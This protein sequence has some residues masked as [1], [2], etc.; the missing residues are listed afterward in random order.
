MA[1]DYAI[2]PILVDAGLTLPE[3]VLLEDRFRGMSAERIYNQLEEEEQSQQSSDDQDSQDSDGVLL[4]VVPQARLASS[5]PLLAENVAD[6]RVF[7]LTD[8]ESARFDQVALF[9]VRKRMRDLD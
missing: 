7:R 6:L 9:G 3:G 4:M 5:I 2:N 1:C 8:P